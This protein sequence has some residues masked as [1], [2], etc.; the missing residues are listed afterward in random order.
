MHN[1]YCVATQ[2]INVTYQSRLHQSVVLLYIVVNSRTYLKI[3]QSP[4]VLVGLLPCRCSTPFSLRGDRGK[5][6]RLVPFALVAR[7]SLTCRPVMLFR[8]KTLP[9]CEQKVSDSHN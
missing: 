1:V 6:R 3:T 8:T 9:V 5:L 7:R 2:L 4:M